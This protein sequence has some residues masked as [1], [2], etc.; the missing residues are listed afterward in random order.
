MIILKCVNSKMINLIDHRLLLNVVAPKGVICTLLVSRNLPANDLSP[1][2]MRQ[3]SDGFKSYMI[4]VFV[5]IFNG[6]LFCPILSYSVDKLLFGRRF[7]F[8]SKQNKSSSQKSSVG[9]TYGLSGGCATSRFSSPPR[10]P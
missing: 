10:K 1:I 9:F 4:H 3:V 6:Y 7:H 8:D 2:R 5:T